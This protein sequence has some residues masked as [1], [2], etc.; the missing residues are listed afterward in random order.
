MDRV[1]RINSILV[2]IFGFV[3]GVLVSS[4]Y[5]LSPL[6]SLFI[7]L[8]GVGVIVAERIHK[9]SVVREVFLISLLI[10]SFG[11]GILRY[12]IKDFHEVMTPDKSGV[13]ISEPE[14]KENTTRFVMRA[15]N[16]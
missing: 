10:I 4:F 9:N 6:I 16:G 2:F 1:T 3:L 5:F 13:V 7:V 12:D 15:D 11:L 8:V 14:Q